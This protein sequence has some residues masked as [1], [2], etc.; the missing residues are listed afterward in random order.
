VDEGSNRHKYNINMYQKSEYH[1]K[2]VLIIVGFT[3]VLGDIRL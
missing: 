3:Q 1:E 2:S